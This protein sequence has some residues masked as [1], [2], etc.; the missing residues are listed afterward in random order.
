MRRIHTLLTAAALGMVIPMTACESD[1]KSRP[2]GES[3]TL[4]AAP[5]P[6]AEATEASATEVST[7]MPAASIEV[8]EVTVPVETINTMCPV[9]MERIQPSSPRITYKGHIIGFCCPSCQGEFMAWDA[10][11]RDRWVMAATRNPDATP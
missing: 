5:E 6:A 11:A 10:S 4:D 2:V 7:E 9:G 1:P 8:T 3:G